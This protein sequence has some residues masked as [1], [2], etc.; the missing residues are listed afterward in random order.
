MY[1]MDFMDNIPSRASYDFYLTS[2]H[3]LAIKVPDEY[4]C[5]LLRYTDADVGIPNLCTSVKLRLP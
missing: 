3:Y 4:I 5:R 1:A 2:Q